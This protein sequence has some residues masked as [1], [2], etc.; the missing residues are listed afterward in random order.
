MDEVMLE[1]LKEQKNKGQKE[2]K[3]FSSKAYRKVIAKIN[4]RFSL[5]ISRIKV[6]NHLK[7]FKE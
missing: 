3:T 5:N 6:L 4:E 7:T 2:E 1:I